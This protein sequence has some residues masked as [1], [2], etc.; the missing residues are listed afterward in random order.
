MIHPKAPE[1]IL[2]LGFTSY[3]ATLTTKVP[4][5][6]LYMRGILILIYGL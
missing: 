4:L 1:G 5:I 6:T 2:S 3:L